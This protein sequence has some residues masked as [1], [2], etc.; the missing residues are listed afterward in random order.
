MANGELC[1]YCRKQETEHVLGEA[2]LEENGTP[3]PEFVS[4]VEHKEN[5]PILGCDG[6]CDATIQRERENLELKYGKIEDML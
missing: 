5:C 2:F 6:N 4:E 1:R 3:C